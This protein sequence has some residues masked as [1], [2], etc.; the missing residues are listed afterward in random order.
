MASANATK[1]E[2]SQTGIRWARDGLWLKPKDC[3]NGKSAAKRLQIV[4]MMSYG[5][6]STTI[7]LSGSTAQV[8]G[9][10]EAP[11]YFFLKTGEDIVSASRENLEMHVMV[12]A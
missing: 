2:K 11:L 5:E 12:L 1:V 8:G 10:L 6:C 4:E 7:P 9:K 3:E